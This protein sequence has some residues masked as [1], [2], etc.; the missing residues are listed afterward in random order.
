VDG[1]AELWSDLPTSGSNWARLPAN[2]PF[3]G[4]VHS[5]WEARQSSHAHGHIVLL[6][7]GPPALALP[8]RRRMMWR[9]RYFGWVELEH[10]THALLIV[11]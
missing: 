9:K 6:Q 5:P 10:W 7:R 4:P 2:G 11:L 1:R 3:A 8:W